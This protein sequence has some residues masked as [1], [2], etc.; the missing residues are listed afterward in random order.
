MQTYSKLHFASGV[1]PKNQDWETEDCLQF[2][3]MCVDKKF[4]SIVHKVDQV[5]ASDD[6]V[7]L[8]LTLIDVSTDTDIDIN[9]M[10]VLEDR[11]VANIVVV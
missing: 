7:Q 2:Q 4:V 8:E 3:R 1:T 5:G 9:S 6:D 11:A 10:L